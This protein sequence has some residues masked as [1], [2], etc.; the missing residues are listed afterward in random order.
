MKFALVWCIWMFCDVKKLSR[1][2]RTHIEKWRMDLNLINVSIINWI[3]QSYWWW[4]A[5]L[6]DHVLL[7]LWYYLM[8]RGN[9][10]LVNEVTTWLILSVWICTLHYRWCVQYIQGQLKVNNQWKWCIEHPCCRDLED[11]KKVSVHLFLKL[12]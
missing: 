1:R 7:L 8:S 5:Y 12:M 2:S 9:L 6:P 11:R 3:H 4:L 10:D